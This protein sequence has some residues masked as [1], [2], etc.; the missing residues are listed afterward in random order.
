LVAAVVAALF[1]FAMPG[2]FALP[3]NVALADGTKLQ[4]GDSGD[5]VKELQQL[6]IDHGC[7]DYAG[8]ATGYFGEATQDGVRKFQSE[9]GL[10]VDGI[11]GADTMALLRGSSKGDAK[12]RDG[13]LAVGMSGSDVSAIQQ[14]LKNLG[15]YTQSEIT[16]YFGPVTE[17]AVKAFQGANG[18]K[19]DGVVGKQTKDKLFAAHK[20]DSLVPGMK[21][22][23]VQK[24]QQRLIDLGYDEGTAN[25]VYDKITQQAVFEYQQLNGLAADGIAGAKT[26][27][28]INSSTART[29]KDAKRNPIPSVKNFKNTAGQ[30]ALGQAKGAAVVT[31][32][33]KYLGDPYVRGAAGPNSFE[34]SGLTYYVYQQ[35]GVMLPRKAYGQ[36]YT[37]YGLKI[38]DRASLLPGDLVFFNTESSDADLC[39]HVGIYVGGGKYINAPAP[40][41]KV[42][43]TD[44]SKLRDFSWGRRVFD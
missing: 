13:S 5:A 26:C 12:L 8:G 18:I 11:A 39:D 42:R 7:Y 36:G 3:G 37:E 17:E 34:C 19:P 25:S 33:E 22:S 38:T 35:F 4:L 29:E 43:I 27:T 30:S 31:C 23:A 32:A 1:A 16:G 6:L 10:T 24:L 28:D 15:L 21:S 40:G 44:M 2:A 20:S 9:H 14:K 41:L